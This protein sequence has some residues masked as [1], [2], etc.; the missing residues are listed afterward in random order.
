VRDA[1]FIAYDFPPGAGIGAG[2]RS[3]SF[4]RHLPSFGWRPTTLALDAGQDPSSD[5]V[6][7]ASPTPW[8][9]PYEV[10]PYGW[11]HALGRWLAR[12]ATGRWQLVYVSCPPFPQALTAAD[13]ARRRGLP[14][15]V[16]FR[17]AWSLDPYQ[18]GSRLKRLL[19]RTLFPRLERRLLARSNLLL[20]NTP[21]ALGA[22]QALYP[23]WSRRM[24]YLP[25]GFDEQVFAGQPGLREHGDTVMRLMYAGRFGI[26]G[27]SPDRLL[28]ALALAVSRGCRLRLDIVG[29]QP[30]G[31]LPAIR[32]AEAAGLVRAVD[33]V[34]HPRAVD[35]M[36]TADALV[37]IQAAS[38]GRVQAVAGKTY[39]YL[40][41]GRPILAVAPEGDNLDLI[42]RYA[43]VYE[44]ADDTI[45]A[46]ADA[47]E[48]LYRRW[49]AGEI[50]VP[51]EPAP[52]FVERFE[53][54][55]LT[56]ELAA[57]FDRLADAAVS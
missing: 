4:V 57:H 15:V 16:D 48:R 17:D 52:A 37:L 12:Q 38:R 5:V 41:S 24:A 21:S 42:R 43:H 49:Q 10:T 44:T 32:T 23:Q 26:G 55:A 36:C 30:E 6:R 35:M 53:R 29:R 22:Y 54:R 51:V 2:L 28:G 8:R 39:D 56:G 31:L 7:L 11:A 25:N 45:E 50:A 47:L 14:V 19:Y 46:M 9:R 3:A 20:L 1:L 34:D 13:Y 18:E 27:R 33:Q 40:R